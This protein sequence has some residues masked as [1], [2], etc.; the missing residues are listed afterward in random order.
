MK[1]LFDF[2]ICLFFSVILAACGGGSSPEAAAKKY[3]QAVYNGDA[4]T[5]ISMIYMEEKD[6]KDADLHNLL[7]GKIKE[8]VT[9]SKKMADKN[10][11]ISNIAVEEPKY[12]QDK[13]SANV[14]VKVQFKN[15][16]NPTIIELHLV[17]TNDGWMVSQRF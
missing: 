12:E 3:V 13:N 5:V 7:S 14:V 4:D 17:K 6:K 8:G 9:R 1:K 11:G 16:E 2:F 10:G 15:L